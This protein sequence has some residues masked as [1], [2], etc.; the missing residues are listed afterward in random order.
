M[1]F[2]E[3][4]CNIAHGAMVRAMI[5]TADHAA[6]SKEDAAVLCAGGAIQLVAVMRGEAF[7]RELCEAAIAD[8]IRAVRETLQ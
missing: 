7:V 8:G 3:D 1:S 5:E 6:I 4:A 2:E